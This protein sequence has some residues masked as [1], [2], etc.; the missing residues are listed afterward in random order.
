MNTMAEMDEIVEHQ[1][2]S[3]GLWLAELREEKGMTQEYVAS[4]L[5]LRTHVV[6]LLEADQFDKMPEPVFIKGYLRA[7]ARLLDIDPE[8]FITLYKQ[9]YCTERQPERALWQTRKE[10]NKTVKVVRW[11]TLFFGL[12]VLISI[13]IWWQKNKAANELYSQ[14]STTS[15][16]SMLKPASE[17][18]LTDISKMQSIASSERKLAKVES[19]R[20]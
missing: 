15:Q 16:L 12:F 13:G 20:G 7:Y 6:E 18:D 9:Q 2:E 4:K 1:S 19:E 5:H 17:T 11:F 8:P 3:L 14:N 10:S